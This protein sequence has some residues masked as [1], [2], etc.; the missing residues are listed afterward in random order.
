MSDNFFEILFVVAIISG[1]AAIY[2]TSKK[3]RR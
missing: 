2:N 3:I 1:G